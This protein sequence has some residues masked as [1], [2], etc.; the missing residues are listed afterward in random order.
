MTDI[1]IES[2]PEKFFPV[3]RAM[4]RNLEK[5]RKE[6]KIT[7]EK[8]FGADNKKAI[9]DYVYKYARARYFRNRPSKANRPP[10][11]GFETMVFISTGVIRNLLEPCYR[12]FDQAISS[13]GASSPT[14]KSVRPKI[15]SDVILE[16][17]EAA[18]IWLK[19]QLPNDIEGCSM[20]DGQRAY[21]LLDALARHFRERLLGDGSEP[22][23][24][25]FTIS[26]QTSPVMAD[27]RR[28][29]DILQ[30]AQMIYVRVGPAKD[31]GRREAYYVPNRILW[32]SR[33]LDPHGQHARVSLTSDSLWGA[34]Q[35]GRLESPT[36]TNHSKVPN[37]QQEKLW[38]ED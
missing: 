16:R 18:W 5:A 23:A 6:T 29:L 17:S 20:D 35:T 28:L 36:N 26:H 31:S 33:G 30:K 7:A 1:G 32:P 11:S 25:S 10:Y 27:L 4:Q 37:F 34:T 2:T 21:R 38:D 9:D 12:M 24:L 3:N 8:T 19:E 15:Q 22:S 13:V 14:I